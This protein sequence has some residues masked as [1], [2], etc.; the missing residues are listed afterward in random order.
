MLDLN[1]DL[2]V[3]TNPL[4]GSASSHFLSNPFQAPPRRTKRLY[5]S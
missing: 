4:G 2:L 1:A 3:R 5:A